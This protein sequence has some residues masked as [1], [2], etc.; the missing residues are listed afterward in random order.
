MLAQGSFTADQQLLLTLKEDPA[1]LY[2]WHIG[3]P[4]SESSITLRLLL[5][6]DADPGQDI[7]QCYCNGGWQTVSYTQDGSYLVFSCSE[8]FTQLR[9]VDVPVDYTLYWIAGGALLLMIAGIV[10]I[11]L[12]CRFFKKKV[13]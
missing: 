10:I 1:A 9:I 4:H 5:P 13:K 7:L 8:D 3:L 11:V 12:A 6:D 2:S